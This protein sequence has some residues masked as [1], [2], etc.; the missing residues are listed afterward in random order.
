MR[1]ELSEG[2]VEA[3]DTHD[4]HQPSDRKLWELHGSFPM[5]GS[6]PVAFL[7]SAAAEIIA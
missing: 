4:C 3:D 1:P 6:D 2:E 7:V 5:D